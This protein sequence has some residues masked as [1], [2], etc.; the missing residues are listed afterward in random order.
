VLLRLRLL[1]LEHFSNPP[2]TTPPRPL[3]SPP[4][5]SGAVLVCRLPSAKC[6]D[7]GYRLER[8]RQHQIG[9]NE[10]SG[11]GQKKG[12]VGGRRSPRAD[13]KQLVANETW[14]MR[15]VG[16]CLA[17]SRLAI[18][19]TIANT[20]GAPAPGGQVNQYTRDSYP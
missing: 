17:Q 8:Q 1:L 10:A 5:Y 12:G 2:R 18:L 19:H 4:L 6:T 7:D 16:L 20:V 9:Q 13:G 11:W 3:A 14:P 15:A